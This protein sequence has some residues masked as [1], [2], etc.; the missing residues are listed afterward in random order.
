[1]FFSKSL[2]LLRQC[3][4]VSVEGEG[5]LRSSSTLSIHASTPSPLKVEVVQRG[6]KPSPR[7]TERGL[8]VVARWLCE[9]PA[10]VGDLTTCPIALVA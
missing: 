3:L 8:E 10:V 5:Y 2:C 4:K 1:V 6:F 7:Q 9:A